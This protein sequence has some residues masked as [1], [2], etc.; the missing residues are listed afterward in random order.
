MVITIFFIAMLIGISILQYNSFQI[1][2]KRVMQTPQYKN[3]LQKIRSSGDITID[4]FHKQI[5]KLY[6]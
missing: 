3:D 5:K 1:Q 4:A 6:S 2:K